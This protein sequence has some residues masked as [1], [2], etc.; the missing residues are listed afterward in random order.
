MPKQPK[1]SPLR[2]LNHEFTTIELHA[3]D[4]PDPSG[5]LE[6]TT[7]RRFGIASDDELQRYCELTIIFGSIKDGQPAPYSGKITAAGVFQISE[8]YTEQ[9]RDQLIEVTAVSI[10][11]G[12]C[13]E[14]LANLTARS[15]HGLLS[16]PSVSF[17][18]P[19][20]KTAKKATRKTAKKAAKK[21]TRK[22]TR[23]K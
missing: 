8:D 9:R 15:S 16:L 2:I 11:Y 14:M 3:S 23:K 7:D 4:A 22:T 1:P 17:Y 20:S 10:L 18:D 13:R 12:A 21:A 6:L 5:E 19:T